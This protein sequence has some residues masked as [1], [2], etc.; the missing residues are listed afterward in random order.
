MN[1]DDTF[2]RL[3]R[4]TIREMTGIISSTLSARGDTMMSRDEVSSTLQKYNWTYSEYHEEFN[5]IISDI[6]NVH[7]YNK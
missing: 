4:P 1:E 2:D 7:P 6:I 3:R 5:N